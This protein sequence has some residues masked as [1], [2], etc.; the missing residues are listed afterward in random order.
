MDR[1]PPGS[2]A[3]GISQVRILERVAI[4]FSRGSSQTRELTHISYVTSIGRQILCHSVQSLSRV[5]LFATPWTADTRLPC[6]LPTPGT[7]SNSCPLSQWR[8]P[9]ISS[10]VVL[11]SSHFQS[12]PASGPFLVSRFMWPKYWSFG[13]SI[14]PSNEHSGLISFKMYWLDLLAVQATLKS[15]LQ[16]HS[17]KASILQCSTMIIVQLSHSYMTTGKTIALTRWTFVDKVI[18]SFFKYAV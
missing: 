16:H 12:F 6:P 4:P 2:T 17:S 3:H 1:S 9:T 8:H 13:F 18:V 15:L 5:Q 7:F 10:T 11:F 14:S